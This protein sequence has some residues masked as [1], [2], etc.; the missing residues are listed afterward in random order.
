[1]SWYFDAMMRI[2][3]RHRLAMVMLLL[4]AFV[5]I[6]VADEVLCAFE[7]GDTYS[8]VETHSDDSRDSGFDFDFSHA[9]CSH[10]HCH[11]TYGHVPP[12]STAS[13][14]SLSL[15]HQWPDNDAFASHTSDGLM[16]P[17]KA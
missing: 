9:D 7:D 17:P 2:F 5:V 15:A 3:F 1:M 16:R 6:P 13:P 14:A 11:H 8:Y 12:N 10:G 4:A